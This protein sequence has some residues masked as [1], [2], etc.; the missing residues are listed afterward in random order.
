MTLSGRENTV[1]SD[2]N[3]DLYNLHADRRGLIARVVGS[4]SFAGL[5]S[6]ALHAAVFAAF[7]ATSFAEPGKR[8][9]IIPEA[10]LTEDLGRVPPPAE[11]PIRIAPASGNPPPGGQPDQPNL[12]QADPRPTGWPQGVVP[13]NAPAAESLDDLPVA[14]LSAGDPLALAPPAGVAQIAGGVGSGTGGGSGRGRGGGGSAYA[15]VSRF[16]GQAGTAHKVVYVVDLSASLMTQMDEIIR[17]MNASVKALLPTQQFHIVLA[18]PQE[19]REMPAK[20]LVPAIGTSKAAAFDFIKVMNETPRPGMADP[21]EAM[22]AAFAV[23]PELIYFLSDGDYPAI[24][25]EFEQALRQLNPLGAV[26]ITTIGFDPSPG[27]RALLQRIAAQHG[28]NCR[29]VG[30][31]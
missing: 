31:R 28:G 12:A 17:E 15:P 8:L 4:R 13:P 2:V 5:A 22:R 16:F 7:L 25:A 6:L 11:S 1:R 26:R 24:E 20:R 27:P 19:L 3:T 10:R 29:L 9:L 14:A 30:D 23:Q 18:M 21:I